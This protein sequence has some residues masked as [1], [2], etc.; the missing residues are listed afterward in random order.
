MYQN[1]DSIFVNFE[2]FDS[3]HII[4]SFDV[5]LS[6]VYH[7]SK[8]YWTWQCQ[9]FAYFA[10]SASIIWFLAFIANQLTNCCSRAC[11]IYFHIGY[12]LSAY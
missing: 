12:C 8:T 11:P 9:K 6:N 3:N 4:Y 2:K 10:G 5:M 1:T 7:E